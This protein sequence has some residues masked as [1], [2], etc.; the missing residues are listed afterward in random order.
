MTVR[1]LKKFPQQPEPPPAALPRCDHDISDMSE[2]ERRWREGRYGPSDQ[3]FRCTRDAVVQIGTK[4]YCRLHGGH[5]V[6]DMYLA[7]KLVEKNKK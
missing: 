2:H 1:Q 7:G 6:L 5:V 4:N 3:P